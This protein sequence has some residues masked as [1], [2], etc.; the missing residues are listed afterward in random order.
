[1]RPLLIFNTFHFD[2][3][4]FVINLILMW[5]LRNTDFVK[6]IDWRGLTGKR[7]IGSL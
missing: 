5:E 2:L 1:M 7:I 6:V 4:L 3:L